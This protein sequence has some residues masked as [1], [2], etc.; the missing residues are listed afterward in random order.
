I[1]CSDNLSIITAV[2]DG[3]NMK[4][5]R[6]VMS[7]VGAVLSGLGIVLGLGAA[8]PPADRPLAAKDAEILS[9]FGERPAFSPDGTRVAFIDKSYGDAYEIEL[10]TR[11]IRS[12][13]SNFP[14]QG[15]V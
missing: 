2:S 13:T 3:G 8:S 12:L 10:A 5:Q 9:E 4:R 15:I 14:H 6:T 1:Y 11:R 7:R